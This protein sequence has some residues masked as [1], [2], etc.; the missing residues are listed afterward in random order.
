M[1]YERKVDI[2]GHLIQINIHDTSEKGLESE[3]LLHYCRWANAIMLVYSVTD[4]S[5]FEQLKEVAGHLKEM[6]NSKNKEQSHVPPLVLVANKGDLGYLRLVSQED[7][8]KLAESLHCHLYES[9]ARDG[10]TKQ[11]V[12]VDSGNES[13]NDSDNSTGRRHG[14]LTMRKSTKSLLFNK[15]N[16]RLK[17]WS[18]Y[19]NIRPTRQSNSNHFT[20]SLK[21]YTELS[22]SSASSSECDS[23]DS[24]KTPVVCKKGKRFIEMIPPLLSKKHL[25]NEKTTKER[26]VNR[27]ASSLV[28][29][30]S[31]A[32]ALRLLKSKLSTSEDFSLV[33]EEKQVHDFQ[34]F[35][36]LCR[37]SKSRITKSFMKTVNRAVTR[38]PSN[39]LRSGFRKIYYFAT[40]QSNAA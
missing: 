31:D 9:S 8:F 12:S 5:S 40:E 1:T 26:N 30:T 22:T 13:Q 7:G 25:N 29:S 39:F 11:I 20:N 17:R 6:L 15:G 37:E 36:E 28:E 32:G 35:I 16:G 4:A 14:S 23:D 24:F 21:S 19:C 10:W 27:S 34:P 3:S 2:D 33:V 18:S 38:S